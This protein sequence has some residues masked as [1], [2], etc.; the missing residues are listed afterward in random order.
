[1]IN[2]P[3]LRRWRR[4]NNN[5]LRMTRG[6]QELRDGAMMATYGTRRRQESCR[7]VGSSDKTLPPT[8]S[9]G[10]SLI[11][12]DHPPVARSRNRRFYKATKDGVA[13]ARD[14]DTHLRTR[15]PSRPHGMRDL[16]IATLEGFE[17]KASYGTG[18]HLKARDGSRS[19]VV[20]NT[21][22]GFK[23]ALGE[24]WREGDGFDRGTLFFLTA[25]Q[26]QHKVEMSNMGASC[27]G[28]AEATA[29]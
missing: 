27:Q 18:P 20:M 13:M 8:F 11:S 5:N 28:W 3:R 22:I 25:W 19:K 26:W 4:V 6:T 9:K 23:G 1:M 17:H 14:D 7:E 2:S 10:E 12:T 21:S 24:K 15:A 16:P 29:T